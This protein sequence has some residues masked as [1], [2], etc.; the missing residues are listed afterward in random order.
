M[1][2]WRPSSFSF[3]MIAS[4]SIGRHL[5]TFHSTSVSILT[6]SQRCLDATCFECLHFLLATWKAGILVEA[7]N[8]PCV[9][10]YAAFIQGN[11]LQNS[12]SH[13]DALLYTC[14]RYL[15]KRA[16]RQTCLYR[17]RLSVKRSLIG[18]DPP[19]GQTSWI[20]Q[21]I[22]PS[23]SPLGPSPLKPQSRNPY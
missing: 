17:N 19:L 21:Q 8:P 3:R 20:A 11:S 2:S 6:S 13:G 4:R 16:G 12:P 22:V 15:Y 14:I 23:S 18:E 7:E 5:D 10:I 1:T 9:F